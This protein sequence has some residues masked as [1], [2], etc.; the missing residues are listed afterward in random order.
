MADKNNKMTPRGTPPG[1]EDDVEE[2]PMG[3]AVWKRPKDGQPLHPQD[4]WKCDAD[5]DAEDPY[6]ALICPRCDMPGCDE[7]I[8]GGRGCPCMNCEE[9]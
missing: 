6:H 7:C 1:Y 2:G 3:W 9:E 4:G 5:Y 8:V